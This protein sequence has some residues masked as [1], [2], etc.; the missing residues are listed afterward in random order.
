VTG[1]AGDEAG[2]RSV[3]LRSGAH[4]Y[5]G[6]ICPENG[7]SFGQTVTRGLVSDRVGFSLILPFRLCAADLAAWLAKNPVWTGISAVVMAAVWVVSRRAWR[8][9]PAEAEAPIDDPSVP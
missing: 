7:P 5:P 2:V 8:S 4:F 3:T 1:V 6:S 9:T